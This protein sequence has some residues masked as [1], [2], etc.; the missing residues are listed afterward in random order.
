MKPSNLRQ[1]LIWIVV[2]ALLPFV[3]VSVIQGLATLENIRV[4]AGSELNAKAAAI[5]ERERNRF[6]VAQHLLM[7]LAANPDVIAMTDRCGE[8]LSG[9]L[10]DYSAIVNFVRSDAQGNVRCSAMPYRPG[11]N[12]AGAAW[13]QRGIQA[14]RLTVTKAPVVGP[15]SGR[16]ILILFLPLRDDRGR[17][18]GGISAGISMDDL[19]NSIAKAPENLTGSIS[20]MSTDGNVVAEG[21]QQQ[22]FRPP[23]LVRIEG[24]LEAKSA[25]GEEWMYSVARLYSDDLVVVYA[26]PRQQLMATAIRQARVSFL[27]P[28]ASILLASMAIWLGTQKLVV[29]WLRELAKMAGRFAHGDFRGDREK[30]AG[31]PEEVAALSADLHIMAETIDMRNRELTQALAAKTRLTHEVH[32]RVKNNLQIINSMLSLQIARTRESKAKTVLSQTMA[33]ISAL[34]LI[35]RLLYD[36]DA[37]HEQGRVAVDDLFRDLSLQF[38][39]HA[40]RPPNVNIVCEA[41]G[42]V[43]PVD[44]A[45]PLSLFV[46][47]AVTNAFQH[48]FGP[49]DKGTVEVHFRQN[50]NDME[51][52]ISDDGRGY[53]NS[54]QAGQMGMELMHA[55]TT[56]LNGEM[57]METAQDGGTRVRLVLPEPMGVDG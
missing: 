45:V 57:S 6:V 51:V 32:H 55:F 13:W 47:E 26:Q 56:Q 31:A 28:L 11:T 1:G 33:R 53:E 17:Q 49:D 4:L 48:A 25:S 24:S 9:G 36:D 14:G 46:V 29:T 44:V 12:F 30:F 20:I 35:H 3:V 15:I 34:A 27:L 5:A 40:Q 2:A 21:T 54:S 16:E 8:A 18:F 42:T 38:N 10:R 23:N 7:T 22:D 39:A 52:V 43:I 19:R 50:R 41:F 37:D